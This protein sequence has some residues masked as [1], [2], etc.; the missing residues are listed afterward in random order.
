M[1]DAWK[2]YTELLEIIPLVNVNGLKFWNEN[3][4][5]SNAAMFVGHTFYFCCVK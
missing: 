3:D 4:E 5:S 2:M 1:Y